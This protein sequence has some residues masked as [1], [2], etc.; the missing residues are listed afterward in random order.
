MFLKAINEPGQAAFHHVLRH[1]TTLSIWGAGSAITLG[2]L[3]LMKQR[4][5]IKYLA[6]ATT[7]WTAGWL[8]WLQWISAG[9]YYRYS[10]QALGEDMARIPEHYGLEAIDDSNKQNI[11]YAAIGPKNF[12]V[13]EDRNGAIAGFVG[14]DYHAGQPKRTGEVR[15]MIVSPNHRRQGIAE[16][17]LKALITHAKKNEVQVIELG[18]SEVQYGAMKLYQKAGFKESKRVTNEV[19]FIDIIK[20]EMNLEEEYVQPDRVSHQQHVA[21]HAIPS[22]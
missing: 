12:F 19:Y 2:G 20:Y 6:A 22:A 17:L 3:A 15:R 18:T 14:L 7:A 11:I 1:P 10:I 21:E 16:F 8:L 13:C 9:A 4:P 5:S